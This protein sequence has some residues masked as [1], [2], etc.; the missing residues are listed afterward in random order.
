M[1]KNTESKT[2]IDDYH[3]RDKTADS[4][5]ARKLSPVLNNKTQVI[6][7]A[8]IFEI[9][10]SDVN[11]ELLG[12]IGFI[13][14]RLWPSAIPDI[15]FLMDQFQMM[16]DMNE[17][18]G[19]Y[20]IAHRVNLQGPNTIDTIRSALNS[21]KDIVD[22]MAMYYA[23]D[24]MMKIDR[25]TTTSKDVDDFNYYMY[26][27]YKSYD[28]NVPALQRRAY[29]TV[30]SR[31]IEMV[32]MSTNYQN[33]ANSMQNRR[34]D[35]FNTGVIF[36]S[37][38]EEALDKL[39][40]MGNDINHTPAIDNM[41]QTIVCVNENQ[42]SG[43][44]D[45]LRNDCFNCY[46]HFSFLLQSRN[47]DYKRDRINRQLIDW[48]KGGPINHLRPFMGEIFRDV[49]HDRELFVD[50]INIRKNEF[51]QAFPNMRSVSIYIDER[52]NVIRDIFEKYYSD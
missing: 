28:D 17:L 1:Q 6:K 46:H 40:R 9:S 8:K 14:S 35:F 32:I 42:C 45:A 24:Y 48:I 22:Q 18:L 10:P 39:Y 43:L 38:L 50:F 30:Q 5:L 13:G 4:Q 47:A 41:M 34:F 33:Y 15:Q 44:V 3:N 11:S 21:M 27:R 7:L 37:G 12:Y 49:D 36:F 29:D 52:N 19:F 23:I 20:C 31:Q 25:N 26:Y 51:R 16:K 2:R